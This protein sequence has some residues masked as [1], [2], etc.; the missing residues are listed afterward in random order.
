MITIN[1]FIS[2]TKKHK[3]AGVWLEQG[4]F[5]LHEDGENGRS[6]S[7]P[8]SSSMFKFLAALKIIGDNNY[9]GFKS[10]RT[11]PVNKVMLKQFK[12]EALGQQFEE[13][14][15]HLKKQLNYDKKMIMRTLAVKPAYKQKKYQEALTAQQVDFSWH[16]GVYRRYEGS[17]MPKLQIGQQLFNYFSWKLDYKT[18]PDALAKRIEKINTQLSEA[19]VNDYVGINDY[20]R[21]R[22]PASIESML[23]RVLGAVA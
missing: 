1:E 23:V 16:A 2:F 18:I 20:S 12:S 10:W 4:S 5:S 15:A 6:P 19:Q 7:V 21:A 11:F 14:Q 17:T 13:Y 22:L 9:A 8:M 3:N